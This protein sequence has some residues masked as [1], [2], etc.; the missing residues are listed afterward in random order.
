[1]TNNEKEEEMTK[2][3]KE[4]L[5]K[6]NYRITSIYSYYAEN[7]LLRDKTTKTVILTSFTEPLF[8]SDASVVTDPETMEM[9]YVRTGPRNFVEIEHFFAKKED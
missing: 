4:K 2:R 7:S 1:M 6:I 9:L 3:V 5:D 8:D